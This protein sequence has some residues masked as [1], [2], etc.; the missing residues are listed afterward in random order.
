MVHTSYNNYVR[1][2]ALNDP[3]TF[4]SITEDSANA[5]LDTLRGAVADEK[6]CAALL[7]G[8]G[9]FFSSGGNLTTFMPGGLNGSM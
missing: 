3:A 8:T 6:I 7:T 5:L 1:T 9:K 4:N 2:I